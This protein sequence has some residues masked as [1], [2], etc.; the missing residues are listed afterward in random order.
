MRYFTKITVSNVRLSAN[1]LLMKKAY[2]VTGSR[3]PFFKAGTDAKHIHAADLGQ[4]ALSDALAKLDVPRRDLNSSIDEVIVGNTGTPSD[5]VNIARVVALRAGLSE[6]ISAYSVHRNCASALESVAQAVLKVQ[7]GRADVIVAGGTENMSQMPLLYNKNSIQFFEKMSKAKTGGQRLSLLSKLPL[8]SFLKPRVSLL[9]GLTD[10][11]VHINMGQTAEVLAKDFNISRSEQD[12]FALDSHK[13][14]TRAI[15][16]GLFS[17]E[18]MKFSVPPK[19]SQVVDWDTG[20]RQEQTIEALT[21]LRP[22]F[23]KKFG[24]ITAGNSSQ[25]TDG[26]AMVIIASEE[27]LAKLGNVKP[28]A[29]IKDLSLIHI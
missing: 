11:F 9:E 22:F 7:S 24:S 2:L 14:S 1:L 5:A 19:F 25:I 23:D 10:P 18:M 21:K 28:L 26:A 17:D 27:G 8:K 4:I 6:R 29:I 13:K 20:V 15:K 12:S 3:T 16:E